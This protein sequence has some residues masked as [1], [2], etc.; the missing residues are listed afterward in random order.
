LLIG[1]SIL[2]FGTLAMGAGALGGREGIWWPVI[3]CVGLLYL[4]AKGC[5]ICWDAA[6]QAFSSLKSYRQV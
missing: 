2:A 5:I 1:G 6:R 4:L 3:T